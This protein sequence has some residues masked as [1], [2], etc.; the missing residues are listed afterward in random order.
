MAFGF[1]NMETVGNH[2]K[3]SSSVMVIMENRKV[4]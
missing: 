2:Y 1:G 3:N 4:I